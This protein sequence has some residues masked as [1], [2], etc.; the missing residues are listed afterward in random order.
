MSNQELPE[1]IQEPNIR[2]FKKEKV[3]SSF[4]NNIWSANGVDMQLIS[5][6]DKK[7]IK[8]LSF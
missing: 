8:G 1:E 7:L 5:N 6:F 2:K 3:Q 4:T